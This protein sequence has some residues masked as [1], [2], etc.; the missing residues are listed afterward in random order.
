[1]SVIVVYCTILP[2]IFTYHV[3]ALNS[4]ATLYDEPRNPHLQTRSVTYYYTAPTC[5]GH[6]AFISCLYNVL[7]IVST[8]Q[9]IITVIKYTQSGHIKTI[10]FDR[11]RSSSGQ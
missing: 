5:C 6:E 9:Y 8:Q 4:V 10:C 3:R 2:H 11:K 1:L 7:Y